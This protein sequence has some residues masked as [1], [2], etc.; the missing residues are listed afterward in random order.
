MRFGAVQWNPAARPSVCRALGSSVANSTSSRRRTTRRRLGQQVRGQAADMGTEDHRWLPMRRHDD[1][2]SGECGAVGRC[3]LR[4]PADPT[5]SRLRAESC[6][7][8]VSVDRGAVAASTDGQPTAS[9]ASVGSSGTRSRGLPGVVRLDVAP[10]QGRGRAQ[11]RDPAG[12]AGRPGDGL[13][14]WPREHS[15]QARWGCRDVGPD[16]R[17]PVSCHRPTGIEGARGRE[18]CTM[19]VR[20]GARRVWIG[21]S[22]SSSTPGPRRSGDGGQAG[23]CS[24]GGSVATLGGRRGWAISG[25][26][27]GAIAEVS[28]TGRVSGS[29]TGAELAFWGLPTGSAVEGWTF[30]SNMSRAVSEGWSKRR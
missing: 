16:V 13:G 1:Q 11:L 26:R 12:A 4:C 9:P 17:P 21:R 2:G 23:A 3:H 27:R 25:G 15:G 22:E 28:H 29:A 19:S 10:P 14:A 20:C 24:S 30:H 6:P 8:Q 18:S 5:G 7:A